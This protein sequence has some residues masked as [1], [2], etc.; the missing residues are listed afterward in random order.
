MKF[1]SNQWIAAWIAELNRH[2]DLARALSGLG[3]DLALVVEADPAWPRATAV[4][5]RH[6]GRRIAAWRMLADEDDILELEP[7]YVVRAPYGIWRGLLRGDDPVKLATTGK[8]RVKGDLEALIRRASYR[9][10]VDT[11]LAAVPT[12][13]PGE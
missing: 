8:I 13:F 9:H 2:P 11:A 6:D 1:G 4:W 12:E 10:V 3:P 5:G 7:A